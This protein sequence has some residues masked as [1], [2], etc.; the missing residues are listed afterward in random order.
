MPTIDASLLLMEL[1]YTGQ[2]TMDSWT[3]HSYSFK[4][5][6]VYLLIQIIIN[7]L[8]IR[9][10]VQLAKSDTVGRE[11]FVMFNNCELKVLL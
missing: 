1:L 8:Y 9:I 3:L 4:V 5:E 11:L 2:F 6:Q 7:R 10:F